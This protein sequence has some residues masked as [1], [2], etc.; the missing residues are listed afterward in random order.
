MATLT[1]F[2][3][4]F[5]KSVKSSREYCLPAVAGVPSIV[6]VSTY[7]GSGVP[8][9]ASGSS[10]AGVD[11]TVIAVILAM[12]GVPAVAV[13]LAVCFLHGALTEQSSY[14]TI[15]SGPFYPLTRLSEYRFGKLLSYMYTGQIFSALRLSEY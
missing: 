6:G 14:R 11:V 4:Q 13:V 2:S 5:N 10:V 9:L 12:A 15:L 3:R 1:I 8:A 7:S